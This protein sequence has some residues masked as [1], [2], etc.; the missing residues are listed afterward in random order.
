[1]VECPAYDHI[2]DQFHDVFTYQHGQTVEAWLQTVFNGD[3]QGQLAHGVF[4]MDMLRRVL[5]GK[6]I[7]YGG[8]PRQQPLGYLPSLS[9]PVCLR[10]GRNARA[11]AGFAVLA[12]LEIVTLPCAALSIALCTSGV[13][14][15]PY[16]LLSRV[17]GLVAG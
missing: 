5:Q 11:D 4:Q 9:Y 15:A 12:G 3:H 14:L 8:T 6:G 13:M 7:A 1:M 2:R 16:C 10:A 17:S